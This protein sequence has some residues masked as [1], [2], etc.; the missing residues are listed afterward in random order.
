VVR[1]QRSPVLHGLDAYAVQTFKAHA[2]RVTAVAAGPSGLIA[3][4]GEDGSLKLWMLQPRRVV[5]SLDGGP[6]RSLAFSRD[7]RRLLAG[8]AD[9][10]VRVWS[11]PTPPPSG[12]T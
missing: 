3:S 7:G 6:V 2:G 11:V 10:V 8:G 1:F 5:R 12:A 9:G 4:A